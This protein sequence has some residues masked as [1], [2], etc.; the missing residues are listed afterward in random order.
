M[1]TTTQMMDSSK[2]SPGFNHCLLSSCSDLGLS[3]DVN[4]H[5]LKTSTETEAY[6][7]L[8]V[9]DQ[10]YM[11]VALRLP[12]QTLKTMFVLLNLWLLFFLDILIIGLISLSLKRAL[13][14]CTR[15]INYITCFLW[16]AF[17]KSL[18]TVLGSILRYLA[19]S[20]V[21][22]CGSRFHVDFH[23]SKMLSRL[24]ITR[25]SEWDQP[26]TLKLPD[27]KRLNQCCAT[28]SDTALALHKYDGI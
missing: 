25:W 16:P 3:L 10:N 28:F 15:L 19:I 7:N 27:C 8:R 5:Y 11:V 4:L 2:V 9:Q 6:G 21:L 20:Y 12:S 26:L 24:S 13:Q 14:I 17:F 23:F 18:K 22:A 1:T